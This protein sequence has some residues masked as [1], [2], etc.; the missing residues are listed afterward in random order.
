MKL[1]INTPQQALN[2]VYRKEK[3]SRDSFNNFKNELKVL[4]NRR[5]LFAGI[6][7]TWTGKRPW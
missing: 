1:I 6:V 2:K 3:V 7:C 4:I 5:K